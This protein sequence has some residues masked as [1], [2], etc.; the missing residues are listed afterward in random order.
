[1]F[2]MAMPN[3]TTATSIKSRHGR[4]GYSESTMKAE[5]RT[6]YSAAV[7]RTFEMIAGRLDEALDLK[8]LA[9]EAC[10]FGP[11]SWAN[12]CLE[13]AIESRIAPATRCT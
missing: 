7:Q 8:T 3:T 10:L 5:T 13:A 11:D 1:M 12:G 6:F 4:A 2:A 9:R